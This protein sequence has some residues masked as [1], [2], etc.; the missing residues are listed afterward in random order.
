MTQFFARY[1]PGPVILVPPPILYGV[2]DAE[3]AE[4]VAVDRAVD[5]FCRAAE[6]NRR[7][8]HALKS[9]SLARAMMAGAHRLTRERKRSSPN[10]KSRPE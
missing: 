10:A 8:R 4:H 5:Q 3:I 2:S 6:G 7:G 9:G 1:N